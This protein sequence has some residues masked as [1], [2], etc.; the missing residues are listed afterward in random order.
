MIGG[1]RASVPG[2]VTYFDG[3][4][5]SSLDGL[6]SFSNG[7]FMSSPDFCFEGSCAENLS[8]A[9]IGTKIRMKTTLINGKNLAKAQP[10]NIRA[11]QF[12]RMAW[13]CAPAGLVGTT[14]GKAK[15]TDLA[16][17]MTTVIGVGGTG[18]EKKGNK[19]EKVPEAARGRDN[20]ATMP[21]WAEANWGRGMGYIVPK[22]S[23]RIQ[24]GG[25][26]G[27]TM[28]EHEQAKP[29]IIAD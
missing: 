28:S 22:Q 26:D 3:K 12:D 29:E 15:E 27:C 14:T 19:G 5:D 20:M 11:A 9:G 4:N 24:S 13:E 17:N 25:M 16:C 18:K 7:S 6:A 23:R 10:G 1:S 2:P 21:G 8:L